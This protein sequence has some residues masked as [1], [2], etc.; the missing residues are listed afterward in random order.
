MKNLNNNYILQY[1]SIAVLPGGC[2]L[3]PSSLEL[4]LSCFLK[5]S[6]V[7]RSRI[8]AGVTFYDLKAA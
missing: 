7:C 3:V 4:V 8:S 6:R 2:V 1:I 5:G